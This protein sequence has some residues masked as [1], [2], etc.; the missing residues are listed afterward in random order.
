MKPTVSADVPDWTREKKAM[1]EWSP[2][3][4][5]LAALRGHQRLNG[6]KGLFSALF[7]KWLALEHRFWQAITGA[8]IPLGTRI[9]GGLLLPHPNG[10]VIHPAATIGP[11]CLIFQ[12]VTLGSTEDGGVPTVGG[13]VDIG[14]GAKILGNVRLEN[15]SRV[16]ANAVVM[17]NVP[18]GYT[19][20]G[21]PA[22][23]L[24]K[25]ER[26]PSVVTASGGLSSARPRA[27]QPRRR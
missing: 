11:N 2:S 8:D 24:P 27:A 13:H 25:R 15:H 18:E 26:R 3:R 1:L 9:E 6:R 4:S 23:L 14:A 21:V 10:I 12:Q 5:L 19:A 17:I 7:R 20:V 22:A 16:G